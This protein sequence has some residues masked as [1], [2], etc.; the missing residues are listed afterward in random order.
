M[1]CKR[2]GR[3]TDGRPAPSRRSGASPHTVPTSREQL[4]LPGPRGRAQAQGSA[5]AGC[6]T[7]AG[8]ALTVA[9]TGLQLLLPLTEGHALPIFT[10]AQVQAHRVILS[11]SRRGALA[12]V[13][14]KHTTRTHARESQPPF[15]R[16]GHSGHL[17]RQGVQ[18]DAQRGTT[19]QQAPS[20]GLRAKLPSVHSVSMAPPQSL[21]SIFH[22]LCFYLLLWN[23]T[24]VK[25][26]THHYH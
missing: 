4:T 10:L 26:Y 22:V 19:R 21:V 15:C 14:W 9:R 11:V 12:A 7:G 2:G 25:I 8:R 20:A 1:V 3:N 6:G 23:V 18:G 16:A 5:G 17:A 13:T 24:H